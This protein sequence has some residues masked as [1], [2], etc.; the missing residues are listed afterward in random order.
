VKKLTMIKTFEAIRPESNASYKKYLSY[1]E[2]E[3]EI[4]QFYA[5]MH[6]SQFDLNGRAD[7]RTVQSL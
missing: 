3:W 7:Q 4:L 5:V 6:R 1:S 2:G